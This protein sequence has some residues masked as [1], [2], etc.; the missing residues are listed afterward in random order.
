M[1]MLAHLRAFYLPQPLNFPDQAPRDD[2]GQEMDAQNVEY[3]PALAVDLAANTDAVLVAVQ[4]ENLAADTDAT[5][6]SHMRDGSSPGLQPSL[7]AQR[8]SAAAAEP[9]LQPSPETQR[10]NA[11]A[12]ALA[13]MEAAGNGWPLMSQADLAA[14]DHAESEEIEQDQTATADL[15]AAEGADLGAEPRTDGTA[16]DAASGDPEDDVEDN[17]P[18]PP[19]SPM[20]ITEEP[21]ERTSSM[22]RAD[23]RGEGPPPVMVSARAARVAARAARAALGAGSG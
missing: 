9:I 3:E 2:A 1:L 8:A 5:T 13:R 18:L 11:A 22:T 16:E 14:A 6:N 21:A 12:A 20:F 19:P 4:A 17:E 10:A 15:A 7:A 23:L